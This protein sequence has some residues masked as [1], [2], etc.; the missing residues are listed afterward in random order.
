[1]GFLAENA[2]W[3]AGVPYFEANAVLTGGPDCPDNIPLTALANRT[4]FLKKQIDDAVSGAL[5]VMSAN[6][7]QTARNITMTGDGSWVVTFDGGGN[8]SAAMTLANTGVTAG[9]YPVVTV[10]NKGRAVGGRALRESDLPNTMA[11]IDLVQTAILQ[12][13]GRLLNVQVFTSSGTYTPTAGTTSVVVEAVGGGGSSGGIGAT[14]SSQTGVAGAGASGSYGKARFTSGF[15]SSTV[16]IGAGGAV[17]AIGA[18]GNTGGTTSF[19]S[20]LT[21]PGGGGSPAGFVG[22]GVGG[23]YGGAPGISPTGANIVGSKGIAGTNSV[24]TATNVALYAP[25]QTLSALGT[26]GAGAPGNF[27]GLSSI[28]S[29]GISGQS[30]VII[31]WEYA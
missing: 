25:Y 13:T 30:G 1:M 6:K 9:T 8:V 4:V 10:D 14:N 28:G 12:A 20:L 24:Q 7:L 16:T 26:Y 18:A 27:V 17:P 23:S 19:G 22:S 3:N 15:N 11:T 31:V 2:S 21:V 5:S 29:A